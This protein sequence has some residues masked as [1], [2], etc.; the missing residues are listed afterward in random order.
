MPGGPWRAV[1]GPLSSP[2]L[3]RWQWTRAGGQ[4]G[5]HPFISLGVGEGLRGQKAGSTLHKS[6]QSSAA[7]PG[8]CPGAGLHWLP[9]PRPPSLHRAWFKADTRVVSTIYRSR[10]WQHC[11]ER[12]EGLAPV[13]L[14]S[15]VDEE[16]EAL[17][18]P[19]LAA[20]VSIQTRTDYR[21]VIG[22]CD[23]SASPGLGAYVFGPHIMALRTEMESESSSESLCFKLGYPAPHRGVRKGQRKLYPEKGVPGS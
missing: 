22:C 14:I 18:G 21:A 1:T 16:T 9:L 17:T 2:R 10:A 19:Q 3:I 6:N 4:G 15:H 23:P 8:H 12:V 13:K 11:P 20:G 7:H 5:L